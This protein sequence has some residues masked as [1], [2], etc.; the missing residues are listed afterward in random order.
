MG[1]PAQRLRSFDELYEEIRRLPEGLTGEILEPGVVRTMSRPGG[2][3]RRTARAVLRS[4]RGWDLDEGGKGWWGEVEAEV[5]FGER[6]AVPDIA[7]WRV[8]EPPAFVDEKPIAVCPDWCCEILSP[9]NARDDRRLK[10]PLYARSGVGWI[11]LVDPKQKLVEVYETR[12]GLPA[13]RCTAKDD[14][15]IVLPPFEEAIR[16]APWWPAANAQVPKS[17]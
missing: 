9:S 13:L 7:A 11:W 5:R 17:T 6:L 10:L 8:A 3:H 12:D 2:R 16:V 1:D 15:E 4:L 14:D